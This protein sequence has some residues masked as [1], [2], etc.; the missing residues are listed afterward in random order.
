MVGLAGADAT[1]DFGALT[2]AGAGLVTLGAEW[3]ATARLVGAVEAGIRL[4]RSA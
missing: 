1:A 3:L 4:T 2:G